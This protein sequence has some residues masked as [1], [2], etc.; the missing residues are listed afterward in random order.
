MQ[1]IADAVGQCRPVLEDLVET[2]ARA[3]MAAESHRA[4][5]GVIEDLRGDFVVSAQGVAE[6]IA[7]V[8]PMS[9]D[10]DVL[11]LSRA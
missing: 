11:E 1:M 10:G 9:K 3:E 2:G 8:A 6:Q 4:S 5:T 7:N